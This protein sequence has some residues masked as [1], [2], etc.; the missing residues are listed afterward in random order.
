MRNR[1][2]ILKILS[3]RKIYVL[4]GIFA[5]S[6]V[7][8][9]QVFEEPQLDAQKFDTVKV[10][11]GGDFA[12]QYQRLMHKADS[13]LIPLGTG[14]NLPTANLN[15]D[16]FLARGVKVN[17]T[18]Y[19]SSR[20]H[21][22]TWVKDG[23][24]LFDQF[25]FIKSNFIENAM[26]Y[27]TLKIGVME[28]NFGDEHFRRSDNGNVIRNPFVGNYVMDAFTTA[29]AA[30]LM[31]RAKGYILM[32]GLT[33]GNLDPALS[34]Y[35]ASTNTYSMY[36]IRHELA[37]YGKIGYDNQFDNKLRVRFTVSGY[38]SANNHRGSLYFGD[39]TGSRYYLVMNKITDNASDVDPS[40]NHL[41]GNWGPGF[42]DKLNS[43]MTNLFTSYRGIEFF[44]T[45]E[46][47]KGT[48]APG[49]TNFKFSQYAAE[50]LYHFGGHRQ[51]YGGARYDFVKNDAGSSVTRMQFGA[52]WNMTHN[53]IAKLEY[54]RQNYDKFAI[55][56]NNA[57]FYGFMFEAAVSF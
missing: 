23:Y 3:M 44:G 47:A 43:V 41:S 38:H 57:R 18:V 29:P 49:G 2:P 22:D 15:L 46:M 25:P 24:I 13:A 37:V 10:K 4:F 8:K 34:G 21:N 17:V 50:G 20:H 19:L 26:N 30:E 39:R 6:I 40:V 7:A 55:Y 32:G 16:A 33:S 36:F 11:V 28:V 54:V 14:I 56:G 51:F 27:L 1:I 35:D 42:T 12:V 31:F 53:L 52:G 9:G 48:N 45:Y 5:Y